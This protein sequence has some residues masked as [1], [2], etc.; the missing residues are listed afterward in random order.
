MVLGGWLPSLTAGGVRHMLPE[1]TRF[2]FWEGAGSGEGPRGGSLDFL[3][4][5]FVCSLLY[6]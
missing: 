2:C 3:V 1:V 6:Y 5:C 4:V